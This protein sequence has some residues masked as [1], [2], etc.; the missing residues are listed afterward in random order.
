M[1]LTDNLEI[2][3]LKDCLMIEQEEK[4][5]LSKKLQELEKEGECVFAFISSC[6]DSFISIL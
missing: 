6:S 5:E 2:Q 3:D 4:N 1:L